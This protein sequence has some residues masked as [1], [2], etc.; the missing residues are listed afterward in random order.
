MT[1]AITRLQ[2]KKFIKASPQKVFEAWTKPEIMKLWF[3]PEELTPGP[4]TADARVGGKYSGTMIGKDQSHTAT[5][6]Y[7]EVIANKKLVFTHGWEG[8]ARA[9]TLVTVELHEKDGGTEVILT[10]ERLA[11]EGV[12]G[13]TQGWRSTLDNLAKHL[14]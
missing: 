4:I 7:Q 12:E 9:E 11:P 14:T 13:H 5:G 10:H 6:V 8:P 1:N 2:V 3:C